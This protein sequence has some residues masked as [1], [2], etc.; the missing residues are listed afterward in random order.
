MS[1]AKID[2]DA[3]NKFL[4]QN[5]KKFKRLRSSTELLAKLNRQTEAVQ[6]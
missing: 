4:Q 2:K 6:S 1:Q 3:G 5:E